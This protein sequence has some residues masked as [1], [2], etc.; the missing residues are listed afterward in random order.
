[1][2][3]QQAPALASRSEFGRQR[4]MP[5]ARDILPARIANPMQ[6]PREWSYGVPRTAE[7]HVD[8]ILKMEDTERAFMLVEFIRVMSMILMDVAN[9][10]Q[11]AAGY[12]MAGVNQLQGEELEEDEAGEEPDEAVPVQTKLTRRTLAVTSEKVLVADTFQD[13]KLDRHLADLIDLLEM[14]YRPLGAARWPVDA[15][16]VA[17]VMV[18][19]GAMEYLE[20][21][22]E[23]PEDSRFVNVW[24]KLLES[25]L[26]EAEQGTRGQREMGGGWRTGRWMMNMV[27]TGTFADE[28]HRVGSQKCLR[29]PSS[30]RQRRGKVGEWKWRL[31]EGGG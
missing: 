30:M 31:S 5:R 21:E 17:S 16:G 27:Q 9:I 23:T 22:N 6:N 7:E 2:G 8:R 29:W 24:W 1:M 28:H 15:E 10:V 12:G 20:I 11:I 14:K 19:F 4:S 25:H 18:T 3:W 13:G 26:P